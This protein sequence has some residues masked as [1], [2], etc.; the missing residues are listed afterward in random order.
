MSKK[1]SKGHETIYIY[2]DENKEHKLKKIDV[3]KDNNKYI[4]E[5]T[6]YVRK[7]GIS[8][9]KPKKH[10]LV[11]FTTFIN[12]IVAQSNKTF[13]NHENM[14][15]Y[16]MVY[17][18]MIE[19][20]ENK[21]TVEDVLVLI[22]FVSGNLPNSLKAK[23]YCELSIDHP[24]TIASLKKQ[25]P[26]LRK[27]FEFLMLH[28]DADTET[29]KNYWMISE[30]MKK[31]RDKKVEELKN[32]KLNI[33]NITDSSE[34]SKE[35][36]NADD[37]NKENKEKTKEEKIRDQL[38][39]FS[40]VR[41]VTKEEYEAFIDFIDKNEKNEEIKLRNKIIMKL[42]HH[43]G[44][45][46]GEI[47]GLTFE[48]L[49]FNIP[50]LSNNGINLQ[51]L[52]NKVSAVSSN[53]NDEDYDVSKAQMELK[54]IEEQVSDCLQDVQNIQNARPIYN[55]KSFKDEK[56]VLEIMRNN[57]KNMEDNT[58]ESTED[59]SNCLNS[60]NYPNYL[61]IR[62]RLSDSNQQK[63]RRCLT[64]RAQEDIDSKDYQTKDVGYQIVPISEGLAVE[65][66]KYIVMTREDTD[67]D[68]NKNY[69]KEESKKRDI[70]KRKK[71]IRYSKLN[72]A[73]KVENFK[74][75]ENIKN[76]HYVILSKRN[77]PIEASSWKNIQDE[78][79]QGAGVDQ[80][81][82]VNK[83]GEAIY[84]SYLE[85]LINDLTLEPEETFK[86]SRYRSLRNYELKFFGEISGNPRNPKE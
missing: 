32:E 78:I 17:M 74:N 26:T 10:E 44:L 50:A 82:F 45:F 28:S 36:K 41:K 77:K 11:N 38:K 56:R 13:L 6:L 63:A 30:Q 86:L 23:Q 35:T 60:S 40:S 79:I 81:E 39:Y 67:K 55:F 24:K 47:F 9:D 48:D 69:L 51:S 31:E 61:I 20:K 62:N 68:K 57:M 80:K 8:Y 46:I 70:E 18:E 34:N 59:H 19:K 73:D 3:F 12:S 33:L 42:M 52:L 27:Y 83:A 22:E 43:Y 25:I 21:L 75:T 49:K 29:R 71:T 1:N 14:L 85:R 65:I 2:L 15:R 53:I 58:E 64:V 37:T 72:Y 4:L 54:E 5:T 16:L 76:N 84:M 66:V 7:D